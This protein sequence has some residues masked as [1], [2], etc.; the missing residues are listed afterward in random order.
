MAT[1]PLVA[2]KRQLHPSASPAGAT[3]PSAS[4]TCPR[5][6]D[7]PQTRPDATTGA[8]SRRASGKAA[9][10]KPE[11]TQRW[12]S[13]IIDQA[14]VD[15][16]TLIPNP[17]NWRKHPRA[18]QVALDAA[19]DEIG[20]IQRVIVNRTTGHMIDGHLRVERALATKERSVPVSYVE[21]SENEERIALAT[22]DPLSALATTDQSVLDALRRN[23]ESMN[24]DLAQFLHPTDADALLG[25]NGK[26]EDEIPAMPVKIITRRGDIWQLGEHRLLCGD[27]RDA[28]DMKKLMGGKRINVAV[29]SP[30]YAAQR[31]Y[32][33]SS[34]FKPIFP[35]Q[36][37]EWFAMVQEHIADYLTDDGSFFLNIKEHCDDGQRSLYVKDLT[38]AHVRQ[39]GWRLVDELIWIHSGTPKA[40]INR[41]KNAWEP[42]FHFT[43]IEHHKFRPERVR[44]G[45]DNIPDWGGTHPSDE[46]EQG[47]DN[48]FRTKKR[49]KMIDG[50]REGVGGQQGSGPAV[51]TG[52]AYP[53]NVL[54]PGK[55]KE[56]IG[57]SAAFPVGLPEFFIMA[58]SDAGDI[59]FDPFMGSGTTLIAAEKHRRMA[60][61][62]EL[63]PAYC[64]IIVQRWNT[65]TGKAAMRVNR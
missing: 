61:G 15:P 1:H 33:K 63:S 35:E 31:E 42:I 30:P 10:S 62:T 19:L 14:D 16:R 22:F 24:E 23:V 8:K 65:F 25:G 60:Y 32:D 9:G 49:V 44:H 55:N 2:P 56:A 12:V 5:A 38:L 36:Y 53:S 47:V 59:V 58:F 13:R 45:S 50:K 11:A 51:I 57:H 28:D 52:M 21:L 39:W 18:Q 3:P 27:C 6:N 41:F 48:K 54:S 29:T 7:A 37:V 4:S 26:D 46:G 17:Q 43:R 34:G 64:D 20:W 40:V